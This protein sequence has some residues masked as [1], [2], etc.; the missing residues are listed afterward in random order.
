MQ[1]L[2]AAILLA[3]FSV[4]AFAQAKYNSVAEMVAE[5]KVIRVL[6]DNAP[7]YGNQ[8]ATVNLMSRLRQMN[9]DGTFEFIYP[10]DEDEKE[11]VINLFNLPK[12]MPDEYTYEDSSKHK[13]QRFPLAHDTLHSI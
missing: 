10:H 8:S 6:L 2:L 12:D 13:I 7:G 1:R 9:F 11:K 3:A 5:Q 4:Q